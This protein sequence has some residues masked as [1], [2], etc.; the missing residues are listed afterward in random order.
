MSWARRFRRREY[1]RGSLWVVP[2]LAAACGPLLALAEVRF[3]DSITLPHGLQYSASTAST[4]LTAIVGAM[5]A[6]TG[7]VVTLGVLIV[8]MATG[9]LSP[10]F[11]RLWYRDRLQKATLGLFVGTLT[12]SFALLRNVESQAVPSLGVTLAGVLVTLS[13]MLFLLYLDRFAHRLR[14][15]EV[16]AL[17][18]RAAR[19]VFEREVPGGGGAHQGDTPD[20]GPAVVIRSTAA[21]ALQAIHERGLVRAAREHGCVL[22]L[23]HAVGDFIPHGEPLVEAR[24]GRAPDAQ[25]LRGMFAL[26]NE[27][28]IEQDPAFGLRIMVDIGLMALSPA[29]NA[30]TTAVQVLDHVEELLHHLGEHDFSYDGVLRDEDGTVRVRVP[31]RGFEEY[32]ELAVV[33]ILHYGVGAV[34][35]TRRLR[36]VL[37]GLRSAVRPE[38]R[39]AVEAQIAALELAVARTAPD[40]EAAAYATTPDRQGVGGVARTA[41]PGPA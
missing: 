33:E 16:A 17:V 19:S 5:I 29:V 35:V 32:L 9:T 37:E 24:G 38:H 28:T 25:A 27:R 36:S 6:L 14:P 30:P 31:V 40:A 22:V 34:Q 10:R 7:F 39:A 12:F 18:G 23:E 1:V 2:L 21:G 15:V 11:M 20:E 26:G 13:L 3:E 41:V 4:V 8:Q